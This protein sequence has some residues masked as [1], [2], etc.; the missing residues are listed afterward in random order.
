MT[1]HTFRK[2]WGQNFLQDSN[3]IYKIIAQLDPQPDDVVI[4]IGPGQGALTFELAKQVQTVH[5][6]EIDPQ[7]V[8]HLNEHVPENVNIIHQDIL[9]FDL[10]QFSNNV[11]II[12]NLPYNITS[13]IIFK[14]LN[15]TSWSKMVFMTQ[16]E[17]A[18]RITS[19]HGN[20]TYGRLS[21]MTQALSN[22]ELSFTVPK[23]VFFPQPN[24]NSAILTFEPINTTIPDIHHFSQIVKQAFSQR[25]KTLRN[26]LKGLFSA[27]EL[28]EF[29]S[30][31]AE[32]L[33]VQDFITLSI[34][35]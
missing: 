31:R 4:E 34:A 19:I 12:G 6:I 32:E 11:K 29:S 35:K 23:T 1:T 13:P 3:I 15:C 24:V 27:E 16:K 28:G 7:L 18:K 30:K 22:V 25:R 17:V 26:T 5:A 21:V 14:F 8:T 2:K 10:S 20:K 33:S 9:D